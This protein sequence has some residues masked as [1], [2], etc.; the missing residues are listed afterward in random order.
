MLA[1]RF[2]GIL[3]LPLLLTVAVSR[4]EH[5]GRIEP[6]DGFV[7]SP[8]R[9]EM[10][11]ERGPLV[12]EVPEAPSTVI[13]YGQAP[14]RSATPFAS[15]FPPNHLTPSPV[16]PFHPNR[17]LMPPSSSPVPYPGGGRLGR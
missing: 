7:A 10:R 13:P 14:P 16:L 15:P 2:A 8:G 9:S 5:T 11:Q 17:P 1:R 3:G 6:P 12:P 4:A